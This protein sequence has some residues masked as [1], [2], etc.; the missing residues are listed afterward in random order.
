MLHDIS[1]RLTR[2]KEESNPRDL[3]PSIVR[4]AQDVLAAAAATQLDA[5]APPLCSPVH[6]KILTP[7]EGSP[8]E[9]LDW[10]EQQPNVVLHCS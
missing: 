4:A 10:L 8:D 1:S 2:A 9:V 6:W 7:E 5:A 3:G